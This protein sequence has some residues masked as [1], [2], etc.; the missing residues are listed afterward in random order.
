MGAIYFFELCFIPAEID[1][2]SFQEWGHIPCLDFAV[3][4]NGSVY[5]TRC[6]NIEH[7]GREGLIYMKNLIK[8]LLEELVGDGDTPLVRFGRK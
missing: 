8:R 7:L 2:R 6:H 1:S 5:Q 3:I 4:R